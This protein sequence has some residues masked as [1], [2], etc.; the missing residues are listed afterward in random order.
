MKLRK[1]IGLAAA[2]GLVLAGTV[3]ITPAAAASP[4]ALRS[5]T[6]PNLSPVSY[7]H[8]TLPTILLV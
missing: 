4:I 6:S 8:L 1:A 3:T 7:T 2:G 5:F